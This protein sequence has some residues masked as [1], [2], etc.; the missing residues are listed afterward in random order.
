MRAGMA[1]SPPRP[2]PISIIP[3]REQAGQRID[4]LLADVIGAVSR[5][6]VKAL[7][8]DGALLRDGVT[9]TEPA[10]PA[11]PGATYTLRCPEPAPAAPIAAIDPIPDSV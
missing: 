5:S 8:D 3:S 7:I 11:R 4:R 10:E 2:G 6:R 1:L 9:V